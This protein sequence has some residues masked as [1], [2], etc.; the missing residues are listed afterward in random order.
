MSG[1]DWQLPHTLLCLHCIG[2]SVSL[3]PFTKQDSG[4][5]WKGRQLTKAAKPFSHADAALMQRQICCRITWFFWSCRFLVYESLKWMDLVTYSFTVVFE[6]HDVPCILPLYT[7][8]SVIPVV[9][10]F[11]YALDAI[12]I[13]KS[14]VRGFSA[15]VWGCS[16]DGNAKKPPTAVPL[17]LAILAF[18]FDANLSGHKVTFVYLLSVPKAKQW[19]ALKRLA[20]EGPSL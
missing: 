20:Q 4:Q 11:N 3:P 17:I 15:S 6:F 7:V 8:W 1:Q 18:A 19:R 9:P 2:L 14:K 13:K 16:K 12:S 10:W 5:A